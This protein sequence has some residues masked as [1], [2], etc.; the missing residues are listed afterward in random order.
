MEQTKKRSA[1]SWVIEFAG[2]KKPNYIFSILLAMCK[3]VFGL[4]PYL[5]MADIVRKLLEMHTG[6]LE[7]DMSLLSASI[8]KMAIFWLLCR[9]CHAISTTLSHAATF[10]VLANTRR[11]LTEKL[12]KLP[13]GS[14]LSQ[15]SGTYK[16]IIC[17]RVDSIETTLAHI[18]PAQTSVLK[19]QSICAICRWVISMT[20]A[21]DISRV[22]QRTQWKHFRML[23][24]EW[25]C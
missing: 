19:L 21:S 16:N 5:Y 2:Q 14:I 18:I 10:E 12:S 17:E 7:K 9:I 20:T 23:Q 11:Q 25:S 24:P 22:L 3:V 4:M 1:V 8:V 15:S 6:T 13:L